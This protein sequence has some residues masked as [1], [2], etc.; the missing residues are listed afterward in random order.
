L[1]NHP[2]VIL[3]VKELHEAAAAWQQEISQLTQLSLRGGKRRKTSEVNSSPSKT[4]EPGSSVMD[5][6][7]TNQIDTKKVAELSND[8]ILYKV[9]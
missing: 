4:G 1:E 3:R 5:E 6:E 9:R 8:P 7:E 2:K